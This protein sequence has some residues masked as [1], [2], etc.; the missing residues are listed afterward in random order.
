[1]K[2]ALIVLAAILVTASASYVFLTQNNRSVQ[3]QMKAE[4]NRIRIIVEN[5]IEGQSR[6][7]VDQLSAFTAQI[8]GAREFSMK[9]LVENNPASPEVSEFAGQYMEP[10]GLSML[11]ILDS[12]G[13]ILSSGQFPAGA[14]SPSPMRDLPQGGFVLDTV[15]GQEVL[16]L[17]ATKQFAISEVPLFCAG[18]H[19]VDRAFLSR[20]PAGSGVLLVF[21]C[22]NKFVSNDSIRTISD[23]TDNS[24]VMNDKKY[25]AVM[26]PLRNADP[27]N[28]VQLFVLF[29]APWRG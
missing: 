15:H 12:S 4:Q 20:L 8:A 26:I 25:G 11:S 24:I 14:G 29:D 18:G 7:L 19:I 2:T 9:L 1:M 10:M 16:T 27:A 23:F 28:P 22:G 6:Q 13:T 17:Q 21:K 3:Q 5:A